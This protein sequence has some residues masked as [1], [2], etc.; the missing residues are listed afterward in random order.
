MN[1]F[2]I[3]SNDFIF[4]LFLLAFFIYLIVFFPETQADQETKTTQADQE[5]KTTKVEASQAVKVEAVKERVKEGDK[6]E[7]FYEL[8][9]QDQSLQSELDAIGSRDLL[10]DCLLRI[11]NRHGYCFT[12]LDINNSI[13]KYTEVSQD[14]YVCLPIGCWRV[15]N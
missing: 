11:S 1:S 8:I 7:E 4:P 13:K 10:V 15:D 3:L 2:N 12:A 9:A 14:D 5:T 6:L